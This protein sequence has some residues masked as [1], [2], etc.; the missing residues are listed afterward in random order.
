MFS[1]RPSVKKGDRLVLYAAGSPKT[2]GNGRF[3]AVV[4]AIADPSLVRLGDGLGR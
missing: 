2:Y 3:Y 4:E 1:R